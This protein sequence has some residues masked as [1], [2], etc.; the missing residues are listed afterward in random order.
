MNHDLVKF[1]LPAD[2]VLARSLPTPGELAYGYEHGWLGPAAAVEVAAGGYGVLPDPP[3]AY[4][5]LALLL[6]DDLARVP[7]L[8]REIA[9]AGPAREDRATIWLYLALAWLY[10]HRTDYPDPLSI[11]EQLY[12]DFE[13]P[14]AI[15]GFVRF[16]PAPE[17]QPTGEDALYAR[18]SAWLDTTAARYRPVRG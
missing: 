15:E 8:V 5:E 17:G 16:L 18:W 11:V 3:P 14:A 13:F 12:D 2:F 10:E 6:P 7:D 1:Q 9:T 4:Q